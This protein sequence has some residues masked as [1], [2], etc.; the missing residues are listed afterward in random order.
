MVVLW[1]PTTARTLFVP[2]GRILQRLSFVAPQRWS[3]SATTLSSATVDTGVDLSYGI[4][5]VALSDFWMEL[6]RGDHVSATTLITPNDE[7]QST[8]NNNMPVKVRYGVRVSRSTQQLE[9]FVVQEKDADNEDEDEE[10]I[11]PW[12]AK[13]NATLASADSSSSS[14]G[15]TLVRDGPFVAILKLVRTLRPPPSPGVASETTKA[16]NQPP[17]YMVETD[18]FVTGPL[19]LEQRPHVPLSGWDV[20]HNVSPADA[21]GHFLL[22]PT[23]ADPHNCRPQVLLP[24]DCQDWVQLASTIEPVGSLFMGYN[25]MGAGASQNHLHGH[26]WP[27]PPI[28]EKENQHHGWNWYGASRTES[29]MDFVDLSLDGENT[30][31]EVTLLDYPCMCILLSSSPDATNNNEDGQRFDLLAKALSTALE[32]IGEAYYNIGILNRKQEDLDNDTFTTEVDIYLFVR[33]RESSPDVL[34]AVKLG[35]SEMMGVFHATHEDDIHALSPDEH[36]H[37][38][39]DDEEEHNH[40]V[41]PNGPM[42]RALQDVSYEDV[43]DLWDNVKERLLEINLVE[44]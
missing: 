21:R 13:I 32:A 6:V 18:S 28:Q 39:D 34:P 20:F 9:E 43:F 27:S 8:S 44:E 5:G 24:R 25:S 33:S 17:P 36:H 2:N 3:S 38:E 12:I 31:V 30:M 35:I 14:G 19:R 42:T 11:H 41:I 22:V 4:G 23:L 16:T 37:D 1:L 15:V 26:L 29:L 10:S 7:P 40:A